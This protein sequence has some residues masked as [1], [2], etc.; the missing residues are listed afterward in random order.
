MTRGEEKGANFSLMLAIVVVAQKDSVEF[1]CEVKRAQN[2]GSL[3]VHM[4]LRT[5]G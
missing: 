4:H 3:E 2:S 1:K 5:I